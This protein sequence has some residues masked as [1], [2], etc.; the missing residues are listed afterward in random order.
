MGLPDFLLRALFGLT[1]RVD[2]VTWDALA[3]K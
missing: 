1:I 3:V 2:P